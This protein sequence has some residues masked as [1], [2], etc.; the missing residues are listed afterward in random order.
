MRIT[1][2]QNRWVFSNEMPL[3]QR[4]TH[5]IYTPSNTAAKLDNYYWSIFYTDGSSASGNV[6]LDTVNVG[7][8]IVTGQAVELAEQVSAH[9]VTGPVDGILGLSFYPN[10]SMSGLMFA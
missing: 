10:S 7:G 5:N 1:D 8:T 9:F 4:G 3:S 2:M 6:Y